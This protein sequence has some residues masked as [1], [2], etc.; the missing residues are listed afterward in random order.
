MRR[1]TYLRM[2]RIASGN[3]RV[4]AI[5]RSGRISSIAR[6]TSGFRQPPNGEG[7]ELRECFPLIFS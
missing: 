5:I 4:E 1:V 2:G 7:E 6:V 3:Y